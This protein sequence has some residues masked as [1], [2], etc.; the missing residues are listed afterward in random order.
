MTS[1]VQL[2]GRIPPEST[3]A[4]AA[5]ARKSLAGASVLATAAP[6]CAVAPV[7]ATHPAPAAAPT[8]NSRREILFPMIVLTPNVRSSRRRSPERG[9]LYTVSSRPAVA[10]N[11]ADF[12]SG[13]KNSAKAAESRTTSPGWFGASPSE[14]MYR[15]RSG[16]GFAAVP[17]PLSN[18]ILFPVLHQNASPIN[19]ERVTTLHNRHVLIEPVRMW[20]G[21]RDLT[22]SPERH[23]TPIRSVKHVSFHS[24][25]RL[26]SRRDPV[27]GPLHEFRKV[28]HVRHLRI[29]AWLMFLLAQRLRNIPSLS[30]F[31]F[32]HF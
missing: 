8:N 15:S 27:R 11:I 30:P 24:R 23:L 32:L 5:A 16:D 31:N 26:A 10:L 20:L 17:K 19:N 4:M 7:N 14:R 25:H 13:N 21:N 22:A 29:S 3:V 9:A 12:R 28:V 2:K 6:A 18:E 1:L